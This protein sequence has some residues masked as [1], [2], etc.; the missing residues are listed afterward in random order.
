MGQRLVRTTQGAVGLWGAVTSTNTFSTLQVRAALGRTFD[1]G[2]E[3][4]PSVVVLSF[5]TWQTHFNSDSSIV[6]KVIEFRAGA[7]M[8]PMPPRAMTVIG[9]LPA[10]FVFPDGQADFYWPVVTSP[11]GFLRVAMIGRLARG[12]SL[13]SAVAEANAMGAALRPPWPADAAPL[14]VPRFEV[15]LLKERAVGRARPALQVLLATVIVVLVVVCANV[16]NLLL[17]RGTA[18]QREIAV[19]LAIGA[20]RARVMRQI[21]TESL[22]LALAGGAIGALLG[23]GGVALVKEL[24]TVDAP[25]IY[26]LMLGSTI[27]PRAQEVAVDFRVLGISLSLAAITSVVFGMLPALTLSRA[28]HMPSMAAR[29][30]TGPAESRIRAALVVGQLVMATILLVSA[31]LLAHSFVKL[32]NVNN[33]YNASNVLVFNLLLPDGYSIPRKA[34]TIDLL[35]ARFRNSGNVQS[36]GF[37]RH[38]LLIGEEL[39]IGPWVPPGRTASRTIRDARTRVRSVSDGYLTAMGVPVLE[40]REFDA[41]DHATAAP[42]IVMSRSAARQYFGDRR[43]VGQVIDWHFAKNHVQPMTVVGVV[44]DIRQESPTDELFPEMFVDY[45]QFLFLMER[46]EQPPQRQDMLAIGFL[47]FALRTSS[48]PAAA[49]PLVRDLVNR[50]DPNVGI[51][52]LVPMNR[53]A[54]SAVAPQRFYTVMLAGFAAV[55]G[56]L[57]VIGVY[58]V[59]TYA[60]DPA[61]SGNWDPHGHRRTAWAG[62]AP[63]PSPGFQAHGPR[64][65]AWTGRGRDRH[66]RAAGNVVRAQPPRPEDIRGGLADVRPGRAIRV[67]SARLAGHES[68]RA[69]RPQT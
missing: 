62:D 56:L 35:L 34:E 9:V 57:A 7:L 44:E 23:A 2:D 49:V 3:S 22:V 45:R 30:T 37:S 43:P 10:D 60:S 32:S 24:A 20:S 50:V 4:N 52:A 53:L 21:M 31:G 42:V 65:H 41:R 38:G 13:E 51:D 46:A 66:A 61:H 5:D 1:S 12:V 19:R 11:G 29:G 47:S 59:L 67:L 6:G 48:D 14:T 58:G 28:S 40:G 54:A 16:A 69:R 36:V 17:A 15:E 25:G 64:D 26:R 33:G 68:R 55:A 8:G 18:R 39:F 63:R 27:L